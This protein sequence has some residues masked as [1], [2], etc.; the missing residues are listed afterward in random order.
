MKTTN[1]NSFLGS[2]SQPARAMQYLLAHQ[3]CIT[4]S[5]LPRSPST[6]VLTQAQSTVFQLERLIWHAGAS[7]FS[8][9]PLQNSTSDRSQSMTMPACPS[10]EC[11]V[12]RTTSCRT[13]STRCQQHCCRSA[14]SRWPCH[15]NGR[16][17]RSR[18]A[19]HSAAGT[20][21]RWAAH[22]SCCRAPRTW[23]GSC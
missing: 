17:Q 21:Q 18:G 23:P 8:H 4:R 5:F 13:R 11:N 12:K 3:R 10:P 2:L 16:A 9:P 20:S 19:S 14:C 15:Q 6:T 22:E 7:P 1:I